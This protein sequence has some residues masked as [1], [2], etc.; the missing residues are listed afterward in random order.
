MLA[1]TTVD[2]KHEALCQGIFHHFSAQ[3]GCTTPYKPRR[4]RK[5]ARRLKRL[6]IEKNE[7]RKQLRQAKSSPCSSSDIQYLAQKFYHL[8]RLHSAE[9]KIILKSKCRLEALKA[10]R[11]C[12]KIFWRYA[13]KVLDGESETI[14]PKFDANAAEEFFSQVYASIPQQYSRPGW[15]PSPPPH[16]VAF[17]T[18]EI[19]IQEIA[20]VIKNSKSK[21]SASPLDRISYRILKYRILKG[22]PSL[23][24]ALSN[25]YNAPQPLSPVH[26]NKQ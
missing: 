13:A 26:G 3:F 16:S 7:A 2:A 23:V 9:K 12:S 19:S 11:E 15:L 22:C 25:L 8:V 10:R 17:N 21:S 6:T 20:H 4:K 1:A 24:P 18:D 5:N 14:V